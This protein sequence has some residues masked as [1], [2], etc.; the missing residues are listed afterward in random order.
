MF[1]IKSIYILS[2]IKNKSINFKYFACIDIAPRLFVSG[3]QFLFANKY[4]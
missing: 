2:I 4:Y 3:A 1:F